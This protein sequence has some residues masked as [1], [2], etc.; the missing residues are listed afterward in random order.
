M[1]PRVNATHDPALRSFVE[2]A[3][4]GDTDYPIQNLPFGVF[5]REPGERR[6]G[7]AIGDRIVDLQ[8]LLECDLLKGQ[9]REA[10]AL[11]TQGSLN[12]LMAAGNLPASA[13]RHALSQLLARSSDQRS[14]MERV[15]LSSRNVQMKL[16]AHI[17]NFSDF[18]ASSF[19]VTRHRA[20]NFVLPA[21]FQSL[22]VAYHSR[23]STIRV[24]DGIRRPNVQQPTATTVEFGPCREMDFELEIGIFVGAGNE[25]GAPVS[26][27]DAPK[28][29]FGMCLLNDWSM[30]DI[31]RWESTPLGPFLAKSALTSISPW[32]VTQ[33]ALEPFRI[34][35][36]VR[37]NS[38]QQPPTYLRSTE[39]QVRGGFNIELVA[40]IRTAKMKKAS[41][42]SSVVTRTNFKFMYWTIAQM[43]THHMSNGCALL[44]GDLLGSGTAS[45]PED[46]SAG[47]L[48]ELN[49]RGKKPVKLDNSESRLWL[50]DE[51][52][53]CITGKAVAPGYVTIGFGECRAEVLAAA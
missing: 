2:S 18:M 21:N 53:V 41:A 31:Q 4:A 19:H 46:G 1:G 39:D 44:P 7:I 29:F 15:L 48:L 5:A 6:V 12:V 23:A 36:F 38:E 27:G 35:A 43:L 9:A 50:A 52:E 3:N 22:P 45:G 37:H 30:R 14:G 26:I 11:A 28:H 49:H 47:C 25:L 13:L 33:E 17:G 24:S 34:P 10:A 40:S 20:E 51:D 8:H 42:P 32:I 16:P